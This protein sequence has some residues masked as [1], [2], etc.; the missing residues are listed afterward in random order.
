MITRKTMAYKRIH[1][2]YCCL[3]GHTLSEPSYLGKDDALRCDNCDAEIL[4][5]IDASVFISFLLP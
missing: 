5:V 4:G 3:C 2:Y 1:D